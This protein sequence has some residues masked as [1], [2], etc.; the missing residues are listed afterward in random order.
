MDAKQGLRLALYYRGLSAVS[1]LVGVGIALAGVGVGLGETLSILASEFPSRTDEAIAA[2]NLPVALGSSVVGLTIWQ[3]GKWAA[4][5]GTVGKAVEGTDPSATSERGSDDPSA[6]TN[7]GASETETGGHASASTAARQDPVASAPPSASDGESEA[8]ASA[9]RTG[10]PKPHEEGAAS[11]GTSENG[12]EPGGANGD[13]TASGAT[14]DSG[15]AATLSDDA[16]SVFDGDATDAPADAVT[17]GDCGYP[18]K[19]GV[20]FCANCGAEL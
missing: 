11:A 6:A 4:F 9:G 20:S 12:T 18:N 19:E 3:V 5:F 7:E 15:S 16:G 14:G 10:S 17:C 8:A 1:F 2:A 13:A